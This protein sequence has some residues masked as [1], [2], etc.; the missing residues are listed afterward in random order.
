MI[1]LPMTLARNLGTFFLTIS[2]SGSVFFGFAQDPNPQTG[3]PKP[4]QPAVPMP[5]QETP[6]ADTGEQNVPA[7]QQGQSRSEGLG[8]TQAPAKKKKHR[9]KKKA[10]K[11]SAQ[12]EGPTKTVVRNGST[13]EPEVK[14]SPGLTQDQANRQRGKVNYLL[15][16]TESNVQKISARQLSAAQQDSVKQI[17]SYME[18]AKTALDEG[19]LQ[20]GENLATKARLLSDDMLKH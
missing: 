6:P 11:T 4:E 1:H 3:S 10:T 7:A 16:S 14:F 9:K 5:Q 13:S 15:T 12:T 2:L 19:D 17:R 18:Q 20:R 8:Q